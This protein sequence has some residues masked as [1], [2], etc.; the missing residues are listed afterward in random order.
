M[1]NAPLL[2]NGRCHGNHSMAD[3]SGTWSD[4]TAQIVVK[5]VEIWQFTFAKVAY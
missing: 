1:F 2:G 3:M 4:V 5:Q